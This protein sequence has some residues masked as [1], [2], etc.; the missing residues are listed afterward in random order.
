MSKLHGKMIIEY[1][2]IEPEINALNDKLKSLE[3]ALISLA[4]N[5]DVIPYINKA[6]KD[7]KTAIE[8]YRENV[9]SKVYEDSKADIQDAL[10][11]HQAIKGIT[12]YMAFAQRELVVCRTPIEVEWGLK[13]TANYQG[14]RKVVPI[15]A[16]DNITDEE[17]TT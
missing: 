7:T 9:K 17:S 5:R 3:E 15:L 13:G 1:K 14:K 11:F 6:F 16:L 8:E 12:H 2:D 4:E 10:D